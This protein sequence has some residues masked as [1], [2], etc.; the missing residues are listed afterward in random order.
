MF[1]RFFSLLLCYLVF[2]VCTWFAN[3]KSTKS[4]P[5]NLWSFVRPILLMSHDLIFGGRLFLKETCAKN[6]VFQTEAKKRS[7]SNGH[8]EEK[9]VFS[10]H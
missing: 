10:E 6:H 7:G 9:Y 1:F 4:A 5:S 2:Y 8:N 3:L